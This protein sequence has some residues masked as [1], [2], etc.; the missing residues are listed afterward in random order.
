MTKKSIEFLNEKNFK[1]FMS[2]YAPIEDL[3]DIKDSLPCSTMIADYAIRDILVIELKTLKENPTLKMENFF[4]EIMKRPD[5]PAIYGELNFRNVVSLMP[6][7]EKLITK[8]ETVAFR[9][10]EQIMSK[11]N[12]QIKD[13][14]EMLNM[15]SQTAGGL[16]IINELADFFEPDV[17][18]DYICKRLCQKNG[19]ELRFSH[20]NHVTLIQGTHKVKNTHLSG[21][22]IPIYGITNDNI[23]QN[24]VSKQAE[25][26]LKQLFEHYSYFNNC[27]HKLQDSGEDEFEIEKLNQPKL[28][29]PKKGQAFIVDQYQKNRYMK[30]WS[31]EQLI[32]FGSMVMSACNAKLLKE[33]PLVVDEHRKMYLFKSMIELFEESRLRPFDLR[34]LDIDPSKFSPL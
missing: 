29:I 27:N 8:F 18:G 5:F 26:A 4:H 31:D 12:K 2:H 20:I 21:P 30:D 15:N 14:I 32:E 33:N 13:T 7:G 16:I 11:A 24:E 22:V 25:M 34:R 19:T 23:P 17:L 1:S 9:H 3:D 10:I 6:D 28:E